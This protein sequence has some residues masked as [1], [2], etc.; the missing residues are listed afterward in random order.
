[1]PESPTSTQAFYGSHY[2][3]QRTIWVANYTGISG[4]FIISG[5]IRWAWA[6]ATSIPGSWNAGFLHDN[7]SRIVL[8]ISR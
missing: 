2:E 7:D 5:L 6:V 8:K 4:R 3:I 1:M